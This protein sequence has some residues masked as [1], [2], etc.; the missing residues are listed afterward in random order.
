[1]SRLTTAILKG[2]GID[3]TAESSVQYDAG[4]LLRLEGEL[5]T[6]PWIAEFCCAGDDVIVP[7]HTMV[8]DELNCVEIP[9]ILLKEGR[10][11]LAYIVSAPETNRTTYCKVTI[12]VAR[13][14]K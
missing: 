7:G 9:D 14:P 6:R 3:V 1:M 2:P 11:I 13:R 5:P 4:Q 10:T 8:P 12:H